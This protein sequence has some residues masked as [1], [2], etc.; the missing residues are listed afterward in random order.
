[1]V[2]FSLKL[3]TISSLGLTGWLQDPQKPGIFPFEPP[4]HLTVQ[5]P[6]S[7]EE[8]WKK[9]APIPLETLCR[10]STYN[11]LAIT[12]LDDYTHL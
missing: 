1:M 2:Y 7:K 10:H 8:E 9:G 6:A 11:R 3:R 12:Q 4:S 5:T